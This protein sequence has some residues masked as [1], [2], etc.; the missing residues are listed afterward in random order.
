MEK[1]YNDLSKKEL[2]TKI[3]Q[4]KFA[5]IDLNLYLDNFPDNKRALDDYNTVTAKLTSAIDIYEAKY[6]PQTN[7]GG[8]QSKYP[9]QWV[10][11]P[12]PWEIGE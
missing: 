7:F 2:M 4:L 8:S 11:E 9:W 5:A 12:W 6:G 10:D 1:T 3:H